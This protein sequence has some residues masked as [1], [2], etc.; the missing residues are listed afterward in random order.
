[1]P[2]TIVRLLPA[3]PVSTGVQM[4][5][6]A[7]PVTEK[8]KVTEISTFQNIKV[9]SFNTYPMFQLMDKNGL[10][11]KNWMQEAALYWIIP[12]GNWLRWNLPPSLHDELLLMLNRAQESLLRDLSALDFINHS[13]EISHFLTTTPEILRGCGMKNR[14]TNKKSLQVWKLTKKILILN[15]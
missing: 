9:Y 8:T 1:M 13:F 5:V 7:C 4:R 2:L 10:V 6:S 11:D 12:L 3:R 14:V 15:L